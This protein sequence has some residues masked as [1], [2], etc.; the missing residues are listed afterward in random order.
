MTVQLKRNDTKDTISY[1]VTN[2]DGSV[3]NLTGATVK[4]VMGKNKKLIT[5]AAATIVSAAAGTVSYTLTE[6]DTLSAGT[7]NAEFEVTF[8][9]GKV[10]TYPSNGYILVDIQANV[11]KDQSAYIEDQIAYRVSD[12]Q[13]LK[14]SIQAQLD[15]FAV[16]A[17]NE[18][19]AQ[20][21]VEADGT[22]NTTLKA[23]L[24]KKEAKFTQDIQTLSSSVAQSETEITSLKTKNPY[25]VVEGDSTAAGGTA[26]ASM[27][28][29]LSMML[30]REITNNAVWGSWVGEVKARLKENVLDLHPKY[31]ILLM[32]TNNI[33]GGESR[34]ITLDDYEYV[35]DT[36][37]TNRIEPIVLSVLPRNDFPGDNAAIRIFN[38]CLLHMCQEK[39]IKFVDLY[40]PLAKG[41]GTPL[42]YVL[43]NADNLHWS[44]YGGIL[45]AKEVIKAFNVP[46]PNNADYP[47]NLFKGEYALPENGIFTADYNTDGLGEYWTALDTA[48]TTFNLVDNPSG[49]KFQVI[50]KTSLTALA[51]G[52]SQSIGGITENAVYR[53]QGE[54]EF[55]LSDRTD[56]GQNNANSAVVIDFYNSS[57]VSTGGIVVDEI[58]YSTG[59]P[60]TPFYQ[61]F[62]PPAGT[63]KMTLTIRGYATSPFVLKVGGLHLN[64][65]R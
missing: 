35:L 5:N 24:D 7:F 43:H 18:E 2:L 48:N 41:D 3:V 9:D 60:L 1:T 28:T 52:I 17:S 55:T 19:T 37:I 23:R 26:G 44:T 22:V 29:W 25:I 8:S 20:S 47:Y 64:I 38:S 53:L 36:L 13:I 14:N 27:T 59:M 34:T 54:L 62:Q 31:C 49:G 21:R 32:G 12:I 6:S 30:K 39:S 51:S 10:K 33:H 16:G 56:G 46:V 58:W 42:D 63:T 65:I 11:D 45:G 40:N 61:D 4:F 57:D 50:N 15:Q